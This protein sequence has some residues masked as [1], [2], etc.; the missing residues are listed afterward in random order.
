MP[1]RKRSQKIALICVLA[2]LPVLGWLAYAGYHQAL[3][4]EGKCVTRIVGN[5][6]EMLDRKPFVLI[7]NLDWK[8]EIR[9]PS[10]FDF[11]TQTHRASFELPS[12]L[13]VLALENPDWLRRRHFI[14]YQLLNDQDQ[15]LPFRCNPLP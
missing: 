9:R 11:F 1:K 15:Q 4:E 8:T 7:L 13:V 3:P 14:W 5:R 2:I 12:D 6:F 10:S